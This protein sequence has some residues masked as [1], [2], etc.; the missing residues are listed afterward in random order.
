MIR[1]FSVS[2][3]AKH[4]DCSESTVYQMVKSGELHVFRLGGKLIRIAPDEVARIEGAQQCQSSAS[5]GSMAVSMPSGTKMGKDTVDRLARLI[6]VSRKPRLL[7]LSTI[8]NSN[9][10]QC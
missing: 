6:R 4:W 1:P 5:G 9:K 7:S 3:L 8:T 2:M 10:Q